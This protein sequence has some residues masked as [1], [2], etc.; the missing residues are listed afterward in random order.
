[1]ERDGDRIFCHRFKGFP[2]ILQI[3]KLTI[4]RITL[5]TFPI[6]IKIIGH[7]MGIKI[8]KAQRTC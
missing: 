8:N 2:Q 1:M 6:F 5:D 7:E 3:N 4:N